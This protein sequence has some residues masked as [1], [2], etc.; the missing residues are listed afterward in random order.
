MRGGAFQHPFMDK[1]PR[2]TVLSDASA[3][4]SRRDSPRRLRA[5]TVF[6]CIALL[7]AAGCDSGGTPDDESLGSLHVRV[8]YPDGTPVAAR[9]DVTS[10]MMEG[11]NPQG[12]FAASVTVPN[13]EYVFEGLVPNTYAVVAEHV[14]HGRDY[15]AWVGS[16]ETALVSGEGAEHHAY[17]GRGFVPR[18]ES[19]QEIVVMPELLHNTSSALVAVRY[20]LGALHLEPSLVAS[21]R[22]TSTINLTSY[23]ESGSDTA[24]VKVSVYRIPDDIT[25]SREDFGGLSIEAIQQLEPH[26]VH[27]YRLERQT[28]SS[29][30][31]TVQDFEYDPAL[32]VQATNGVALVLEG[33]NL[34]SY[35][36]P[37]ELEVTYIWEDAVRAAR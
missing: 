8:T 22:E 19:W 16:Y 36:E 14:D 35:F 24:E 7:Y 1:I 34:T 27:T 2:R 25:W 30:A 28:V 17:V 18:D 37:G 4:S 29:M 9:I 11:G 5:T 33:E 32:F 6:C 26:E 21:I 20:E 12:S 10:P 3:S 31:L 15:P 13:G 23:D